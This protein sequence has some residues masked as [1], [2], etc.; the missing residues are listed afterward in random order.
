MEIFACLLKLLVP[1]SRTGLRVC[2][3]WALWRREKLLQSMWSRFFFSLFRIIDSRVMTF[4][5]SL[6]VDHVFGRR[7]K[8]LVSL[9]N[10]V[11]GIQ[12]ILFRDA[13]SPGP[14]AEH[15][16]FGADASEFGTR[17]VGTETGHQFESN[18]PIAIHAFGMNLED[19]ATS[20][21]IG[22]A[23]FDL[24]VQSTGSQEGRIQ[25]VWTIG[26]H[27]NL[28]IAS[29]V[30]TIQFGNN[31]QHGSLDFIVGSIFIGWS[32]STANGID[33]I[34]KDNASPLG[35]GHG[36]QFSHHSS[37][38]AHVLLDQF[39]SNDSNE[40]SIGT[41]GHRTSTQCLAGSG[42]PVQQDSLGWINSQ[43]DESFRMKQ[44]GLQDL[45]KFLHGILG[46]THI[47]V[48]DIGFVFHGH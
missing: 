39:T 24:A 12:K 26:G 41:I 3:E 45:P 6:V 31:L 10:L 36:K 19:V 11:D 1:E 32:T 7:G 15:A 35:T 34:K 47:I 25:R 40:T 43:R 48:G 13:L 44:G 33:F 22:Q 38:L 17:R 9:D 27:E 28:D 21:Q 5:V 46:T 14:D 23:E 30:K 29:S 37:T 2:I 20:L 42:R 8:L 4:R 16:R 18:V